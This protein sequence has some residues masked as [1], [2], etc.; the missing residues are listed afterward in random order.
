PLA[1]I[2]ARAFA[3]SGLTVEDWNGLDDETRATKIDIVLDA[4]DAGEIELA[5]PAAP[6]RTRKAK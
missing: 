4:L 6:K 2:V 5:Q 3:D 1:D